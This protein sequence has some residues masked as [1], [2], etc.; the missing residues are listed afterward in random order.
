MTQPQEKVVGEDI[1]IV[2]IVTMIVW[3][4]IFFYLM[5]LDRKVKNLEKRIEMDEET[6]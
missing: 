3:G 5:Y 4:G 2:M 1:Y 6:V